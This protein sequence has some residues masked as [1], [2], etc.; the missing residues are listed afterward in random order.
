MIAI[1]K[2]GIAVRLV[3]MLTGLTK[4]NVIGLQNAIDEKNSFT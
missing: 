3:T 4:I 2:Q 1:G